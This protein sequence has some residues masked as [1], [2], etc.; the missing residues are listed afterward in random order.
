[1]ALAKS[2][3]V[4][5]TGS[6]VGKSLLATALCRIF[7]HDGYR[8]LP[9][10]AQNM[11]N[12]SAV[13]VDGGELGRAQAEQAAACKAD[14]S[15]AMNPILLKPTTD[16]GAQ[17][18]VMGRAIGTMD[19]AAYH[20]FK[21]ALRSTIMEAL[22]TL[23]Q[24]ADI[25]VIE[26]AGSPAEINLKADDLA[27]MWVAE[28]AD[29]V[30]LLV[31]DIDRGGVFA[32]LVGTMELLDAD[33]RRRVRGFLIN[34]F[35][36]TRSLLEPG[37][38][39]LEERFGLP[40]VGTVPYLEVVELAEEDAAG[41]QLSASRAASGYLLVD[42]VH[43]PRISNFTDFDALK[44]E[45]D[46]RLRFLDRPDEG[47][48]P[49]CMIVP[50]TKST[51][52]DLAWLRK[53]GF[54]SYLRRCVSSGVELI[55]VCGGFQMLGRQVRDPDHVEASVDAA[56]GL[57][58]LPGVTTFQTNKVVAHV[59]GVH[60]ESGLPISGYEIHMGRMAVEPGASAVLKMTH[61]GAQSIEADDGLSSGDGLVWGVHVHGIFDEDRFRAWWLQRLRRRK[62]VSARR[63]D[64]DPVDRP[65]A[66]DRYD[67]LADAVRPHLA[68]EEIYAM[69]SLSQ[70]E[71]AV[72]GSAVVP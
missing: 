72:P 17:I 34:K 32:Q 35:R 63:G 54:E 28:Q 47:P 12:N 6:S 2:I 39:W 40:V 44:R 60:V 53:R 46:V 15:V 67:R 51:I 3:M 8:V 62:H 36:G 24:Q 45:P 30:V 50:G 16:V 25:L 10:K 59:R 27:N 57:G 23:R 9:F 49:D 56:E 31:G 29:A 64:A 70:R 69:L 18:I 55:G 42:V 4:Q 48:L 20:A 66:A 41:H 1:M 22:H 68:M 43:L 37:L 52:A 58:F 61:R 13:A 21:P 7:T 5:G 26:G 11:S 65:S 19:A 14:P 33:E 71:P 38:R